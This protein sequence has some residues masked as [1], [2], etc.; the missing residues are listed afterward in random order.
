MGVQS[1]AVTMENRMEFSQKIKNRNT[2]WSS[3]SATEYLPE[4]YENSNLKRYMHPYVHCS[5]VYNSQIMEAA[6]NW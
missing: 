4:E 5:F 6:H 2:L 3:N 1:G